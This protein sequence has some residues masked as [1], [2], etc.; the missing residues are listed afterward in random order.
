MDRR[1]LLKRAAGGVVPLLAADTL[2]EDRQSGRSKSVPNEE[3]NRAQRWLKAV[4]V[5]DGF[6]MAYFLRNVDKGDRRPDTTGS[7]NNAGSRGR[8][9]PYAVLDVE[10]G[11]LDIAA[12]VGR[13]QKQAR[14]EAGDG[15]DLVNALL[16]T[17]EQL[18][19]HACYLPRHLVV[20][21]SPKGQPLGVV[22]VCFECENYKM[23][24]SGAMH[25][26]SLGDL[27]AVA[28]ILHKAGLPL[29]DKFPTL[30]VYEESLKKS[31][32]QLRKLME[33]LRT[34]GERKSD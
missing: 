1:E 11:R 17:R 22:E 30:A 10:S 2:G 19:Q 21:Y 13:V 3:R 12:L 26:Q 32:E 27:L 20:F 8:M 4:Q 5:P 9:P 31:R 15:K 7:A 25:V 23:H 6:V 29:G 18:N 28:R 14:L 24:P 16:D 33:E 34:A